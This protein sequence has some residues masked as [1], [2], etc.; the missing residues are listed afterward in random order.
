MIYS[1]NIGNK[2]AVKFYNSQ[3]QIIDSFERG[4]S[5]GAEYL[6]AIDFLENLTNVKPCYEWNIAQEP[7]KWST[8]YILE[9]WKKWFELNKEIIVWDHDSQS[10]KFIAP[11][12]YLEKKPKDEFLKYYNILESNIQGDYFNATELWC[13]FGFFHFTKLYREI[14][15]FEDNQ[16][17][18]FHRPSNAY[19]KRLMKWYSENEQKLVW[20]IDKQEVVVRE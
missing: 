16:E 4:N 5:A 12:R 15:D 18:D 13:A 7:D 11:V 14:T 10:I 6:E 9:D 1:Q 8:N 19:L 20:D 3:I 17:L 2:K